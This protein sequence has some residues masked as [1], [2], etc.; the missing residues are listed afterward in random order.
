MPTI[1]V[2]MSVYNGAA[3]LNEAIDS[4][5]KQTFEN[6]EF[7]IIDD[8]STDRSNEIVKSYKDKRIVFIEQ[9]NTG[10]AI[11]LNN[12]IRVSKTNLIARMDADDISLPNRLSLQFAFLENHAECIAVGGNAEIIDKDGIYVYTSKQ[13]VEWD[14]IKDILPNTPFYHSSTMYR[15]S[16]FEKAGGYPEIYGIEDIVF[17]NRLSEIGELRNLPDLLIK[18]RLVPTAITT[19]SG[20]EGKIIYIILKQIIRDNKLSTENKEK[21]FQIKKN[22]NPTEKECIY[23][24]HLAKKYLFNNYQLAKA[25]KNL[26]KAI[27]IKLTDP[28]PYVLYFLTFFP[29][30]VINYI[31]Q[32]KKN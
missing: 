27:K 25:R 4:I 12:A 18:Y 28:L 1:S 13:R 6:F 29:A 32:R 7:I 21:L 5:L 17:F 22:I 26:L 30:S 8:G 16:A 14:E 23:F 3:Y 24:I 9:E 20:K 15:K 19:K 31:Y 10:L 11:A 2:V